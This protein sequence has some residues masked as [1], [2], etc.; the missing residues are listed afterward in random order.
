M[1]HKHGLLFPGKIHQVRNENSFSFDRGGR[2]GQLTVFG[3][4]SSRGLEDAG[5]AERKKE[6]EIASTDLP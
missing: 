6:R 2:L 5:Q 4:A 3:S 1:T